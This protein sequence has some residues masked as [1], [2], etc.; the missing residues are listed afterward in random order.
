MLAIIHH[1]PLKLLMN[2]YGVETQRVDWPMCPC[3]ILLEGPT[4]RAPNLFHIINGTTLKKVLQTQ[5][6]YSEGK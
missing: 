6:R 3:S 1:Q 5:V 2:V 4:R